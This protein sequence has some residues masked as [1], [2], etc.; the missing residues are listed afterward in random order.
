MGFKEVCKSV[1]GFIAEYNQKTQ[2]EYQQYLEGYEHYDVDQLMR[3]YKSASGVK[4]MALAALIREK[5]GS[6][7]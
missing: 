7:E 5:N 3:I 4:K 2:E 1:L 6:L